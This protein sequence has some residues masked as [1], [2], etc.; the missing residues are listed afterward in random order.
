MR[1]TILILIAL[2]AIGTGIS[3]LFAA[4]NTNNPANTSQP[5]YQHPYIEE[6]GGIVPLPDAAEQPQPDSK[7]LIDIKADN[8]PAKVTK[9]LDRAALITNQ[10]AVAGHKPPKQFKMTV[11]LHGPATKTA[12]NHEAYAKHTEVEENPNIALLKKLDKAGIEV[13]VCGQAMAHHRFALDSVTKSV[14]V[15]ASAATV[16]IN[17]QM[18]GY[19]VIAF[20]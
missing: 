9:G 5:D 4:T 8:G 7:V 10:Y 6:H 16:N 12:L 20:Q 2:L 3:T 11:I 18:A 19:A 13:L 1:R 15:A 14:D 17:K